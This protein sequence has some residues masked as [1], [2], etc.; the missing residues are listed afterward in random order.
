MKDVQWL[1]GEP[2]REGL[3][4]SLYLLAVKIKAVIVSLELPRRPQAE[5]TTR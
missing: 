2:S 5:V 1:D 4:S 3:S